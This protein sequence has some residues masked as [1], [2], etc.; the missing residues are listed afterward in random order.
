MP[1]DPMDREPGYHADEHGYP[2]SSLEAEVI[3]KAG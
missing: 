3:V 2:K 1:M